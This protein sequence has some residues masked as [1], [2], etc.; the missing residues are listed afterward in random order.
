MSVSFMEGAALPGVMESW[1]PSG[2]S[3]PRGFLLSSRNGTLGICAVSLWWHTLIVGVLLGEIEDR[4]GITEPAALVAR[5]P[6]PFLFW[7]TGMKSPL[8]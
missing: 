3:S 6:F 5:W 7:S 8:R 4:N 1:R 2:Y